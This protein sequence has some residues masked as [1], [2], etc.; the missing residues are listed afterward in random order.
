MISVKC[1]SLRGVLHQAALAAG[2]GGRLQYERRPVQL[3]R[4]LGSLSR[5]RSANFIGCSVA[6]L[7]RVCGCRFSTRWEQG[8][9]TR[10]SG[11]QPPE[12]GSH[13][14]SWGGGGGRFAHMAA[15]AVPVRA[16][17]TSKEDVILLD[18]GGMLFF[19]ACIVITHNP[20]RLLAWFS[21][22]KAVAR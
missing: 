4:S 19:S 20:E 12:G 1:A 15:F 6:K 8:P 18:V 2:A 13:G 16:P 14:R 21:R 11:P 10:T 17:S 5:S 22:V 7:C 3:A 9:C